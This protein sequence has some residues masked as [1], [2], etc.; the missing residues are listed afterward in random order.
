MTTGWDIYVDERKDSSGHPSEIGLLV[1]EA[2]VACCLGAL[3]F[4]EKD[5]LRC[6]KTK[7]L[8]SKCPIG[9]LHWTDMKS[10]EAELACRWIDRFL[11]GPLM[12]FVLAAAGRDPRSRLC[13]VMQAVERLECDPLVPGGLSRGTSTVHL[14]FDVQDAKSAHV[15][16]VRGFGLLRAFPC[17]D[18]GSE[19]LQLADILL[20]ISYQAWHESPFGTSEH[21]KRRK[22]VY[23]HTFQAI[24]HLQTNRRRAN[25]IVVLGSDGK[26]C[27]LFSQGERT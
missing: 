26:A 9:S 20:G 3:L 25:A 23:I 6:Q 21:E 12:F 4:K 22:S 14:D 27:R 15:E 17:N 19:L 7:H 13:Q 24:R 11:A 1:L 8:G 2:G 10:L 5:R 18:R 16:L